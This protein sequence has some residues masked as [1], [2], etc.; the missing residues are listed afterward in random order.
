MNNRV[1]KIVIW[2]TLLAMLFTTLLMSVGA[3]LQ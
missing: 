3:F 1:F 2:V